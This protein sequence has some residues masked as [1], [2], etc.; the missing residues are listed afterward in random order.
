MAISAPTAA[1]FAML[2]ASP[3]Q[4]RPG[5]RAGGHRLKHVAVRTICSCA[6]SG[7]LVIG[8][9]RLPAPFSYQQPGALPA[10]H[11]T[12]S[13]V[14]RSSSVRCSPDTQRGPLRQ[15]RVMQLCRCTKCHR[16]HYN[17]TAATI[18]ANPPERCVF[19]RTGTPQSTAPDT[20]AATAA[21]WLVAQSMRCSYFR[22]QHI[23]DGRAIQ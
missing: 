8:C 1:T 13:A 6:M 16:P 22:Q 9:H 17:V 5:G 15:L 11:V 19:V 23:A 7:V 4:H 3:H 14:Y 12:S 2:S 18:L 20:T 10:S 21:N